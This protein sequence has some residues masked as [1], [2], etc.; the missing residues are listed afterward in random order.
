MTELFCAVHVVL[1]GPPAHLATGLSVPTTH[2]DHLFP[3]SEVQL[4]HLLNYKLHSTIQKQQEVRKCEICKIFSAIFNEV[5]CLP[6]FPHIGVPI[7][8]AK[9][10]PGGTA[11]GVS[12]RSCT[13]TMESQSLTYVASSFCALDTGAVTTVAGCRDTRIVSNTAEMK[14]LLLSI[15]TDALESTTN[16]VSSIL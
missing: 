9:F 1:F 3:A 8:F 6:F 11:A 16:A 10:F 12:P 7:I 13:L 5:W 2:P 15:R 14:S 4:G